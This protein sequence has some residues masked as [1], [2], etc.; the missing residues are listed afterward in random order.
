MRVVPPR[1][2]PYIPGFGLYR[3]GA[4]NQVTRKKEVHSERLCSQAPPNLGPRD[5]LQEALEQPGGLSEIVGCVR[6]RFL[7]E[8]LAFLRVSQWFVIQKY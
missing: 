3:D 4:S 7:G 6:M 5:G 8:S 1:V 2:F